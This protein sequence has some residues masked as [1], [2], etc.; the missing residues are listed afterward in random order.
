MANIQCLAQL[1]QQGLHG[2]MFG[3]SEVATAITNDNVRFTPQHKGYL[4]VF[5]HSDISRGV[6]LKGLKYELSDVTLTSGVPLGVSNE[7]IGKDSM[8]SVA[9]GTLLILYEIGEE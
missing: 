9:N 5:S 7:F 3:Q 1:S 6:T 2:L 8:V 4:S